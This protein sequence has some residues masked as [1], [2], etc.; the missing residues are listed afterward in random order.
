MSFEPFVL[1]RSRNTNMCWSNSKLLVQIV[2]PVFYLIIV[3]S[4][5]TNIFIDL[6]L[7]RSLTSKINT[8]MFILLFMETVLQR[9]ICLWC[10]ILC[11]EFTFVNTSGFVYLLGVFLCNMICSSTFHV[12]LCSS[13]LQHFL[14]CSVNFQLGLWADPASAFLSRHQ[15]N[16]QCE[17]KPNTDYY[18]SVYS[19]CRTQ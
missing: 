7:Y 1:H 19:H 18:L 10:M 3:F 13:S 6:C 17:I 14:L 11:R 8:F 5:C 9:N 12:S 2:I 15:Y 16:G 4:N